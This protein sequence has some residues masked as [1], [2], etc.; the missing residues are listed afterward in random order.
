MEMRAL[1][2]KHGLVLETSGVIDSDYYD[3]YTTNGNI[4]IKL[5]NNS[6]TPCVIEKGERICQG[7]FLKYLTV[8][9]D[10]ADGGRI[11]GFGSTGK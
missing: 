2:T 8:D 1:A 5:R 3:N 7:V 10:K 4:A 9:N 6:D 11:G